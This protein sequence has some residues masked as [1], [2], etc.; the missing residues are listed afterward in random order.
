MPNK[1]LVVAEQRDCKL[2]KVSL[3]MLG[4]GR[5]I[6]EKL[7]MT[8]EAAVIGHG[9]AALAGVLAQYGADKVY[10]ADNPLLAR[11]SP[12]GYAEILAG[13]VK[14]TGPTVI[15]AAATTQGNDLA[16]R[17]AAK[18]GAGLA[19]GCTAFEV[20]NGRLVMTRS[21]CGG[22]AIA[23][24]CVNTTPQMVTVP[25][26]AFSALP[27]DD[28]RQAAVENLTVGAYSPKAV[29]VKFTA[30]AGA[31]LDVAEANVIVSGGRGM[32][33]PENYV[34]L[35]TLAGLL[36]AA[37]GA[38]RAAVD[39]GWR[40]HADQVGQ[41]GKTVSPNLYI[42]CGISGAIQHLAGMKTSKCIVAINKDPEAPIFKIATYGIVGDLF[43][44]VPAL[45]EEIRKLKS[46]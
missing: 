13:L 36:N 18:L 4:E 19:S 27:A 6:A 44:V 31:K 41:T 12:D 21:I 16:P 38:S 30:T 20:D 29:V 32:S 1:I 43:K 46:E 2:K 7:G 40:P 14:N 37:V 5:R 9:V 17:L 24:V 42:A 8:V 10:I 26:N 35:E 45:I 22:R 23:K 39:A 3:E 25:P 34:L 15:L 11:F 33:K 28:S